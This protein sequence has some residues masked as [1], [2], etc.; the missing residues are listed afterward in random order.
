MA[1]VP[2][3]DAIV[4]A[5]SRTTEDCLFLDVIT[6]QAGF[7]KKENRL[8]VLIYVRNGLSS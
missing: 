3:S 4:S 7:A 8:P 1:A 6:P 5:D 2:K